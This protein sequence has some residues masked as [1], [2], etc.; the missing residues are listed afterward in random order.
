MLACVHVEVR[1]REH[2]LE[3]GHSK[4]KKNTLIKMI[5]KSTKET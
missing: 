4:T 2:K 3:H 1:M 5:D